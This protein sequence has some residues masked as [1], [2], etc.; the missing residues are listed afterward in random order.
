MEVGVVCLCQRKDWPQL[1]TFIYMLFWEGPLQLA[2]DL[3]TY[4]SSGIFL[5]CRGMKV[6]AVG[7]C[8]KGDWPQMTSYMYMLLGRVCCLQPGD[9]CEF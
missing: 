8:Q 5:K 7:F 1:T 6:G 4:V 2:A 3:E 9:L